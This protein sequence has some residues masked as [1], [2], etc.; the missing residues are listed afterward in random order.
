M[1]HR[2]TVPGEPGDILKDPQLPYRSGS[3]K[4][5]FVQ[6]PHLISTQIPSAQP[7]QLATSSRF[8]HL[9]N[10]A[11]LTEVEEMKGDPKSMHMLR[12]SPKC[13]G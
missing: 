4:A 8:C 3:K 1:S 11:A 9:T 10:C 5:H 13:P 7:T 2:D 12:S 6:P